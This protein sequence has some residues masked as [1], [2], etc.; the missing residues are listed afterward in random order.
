M[1][2]DL[3]FTTKKA[4]CVHLGEPAGQEIA[5]LLVSLTERI[6]HLEQNKVDVIPIIPTRQTKSGPESVR[7]AA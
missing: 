6:E 7:R 5:Q 1:N 3:S 4:L 2:L